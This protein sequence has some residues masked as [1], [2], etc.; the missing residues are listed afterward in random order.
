[1][2]LIIPFAAFLHSPSVALAGLLGSADG[3]AVLGASTVTNTGST[4]ITGD[5]GLYSGTSITG[6][7]SVTVTGTVHQTDTAAQQAQIDVTT[8]YNTLALMPSTSN[9]SGQNLGGLTLTPGVYNFSSSA[10]LTETLNLDGSSDPAALF[11]FQIGTTLTT[12][13]GAAVYVFGGENDRVFWQVGSS[14]T[15]GT[16][17]SFAG[18]ILA[19]AS[20]TM[21][22]GATIPCGRALART[23][24]V[25]L[26]T[27]AITTCSA[28][29]DVPE[30]PGT[31]TGTDTGT[32]TGNGTGTEPA[33][34]N[35]VAEVPEPGTVSLFCVG[36]L[37]LTLYGW[38]SR[39]RLA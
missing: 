35:G 25:T 10:Q 22:T 27:N 16:G 15:L 26:D 13:S 24:A 33:P 14:A 21:N 5:L 2:V 34:G 3:F 39:K 9:L 38:Q 6:L 36:L 20:V 11:V 23:G 17:T 29:V 37:A 31:G 28:V 19:M 4:S 12:A 30:V 7:A 8:A 18:S 32:G 1:M